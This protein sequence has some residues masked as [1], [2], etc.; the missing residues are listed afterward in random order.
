MIAG[1]ADREKVQW[2][3]GDK[4]RPTKLLMTFEMTH[5]QNHTHR[6]Y[7]LYALLLIDEPC[8]ATR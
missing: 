4:L 8:R 2:F 5:E 1:S 7:L 6:V 3:I